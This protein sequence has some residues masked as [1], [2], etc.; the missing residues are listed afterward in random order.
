MFF[1]WQHGHIIVIVIIVFARRTPM[2]ATAALILLSMKFWLVEDKMYNK[3]VG[4]FSH[5]V[6]SVTKTIRKYSIITQ[7]L[8]LLEGMV[9]LLLIANVATCASF[10]C[11]RLE[12]RIC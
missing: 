5:C 4:L 2:A 1:E 9:L 6:C 3:H 11:T 8:L 7:Y 12:L 10:R